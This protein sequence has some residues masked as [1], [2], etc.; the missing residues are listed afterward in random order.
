MSSSDNDFT[1]AETNGFLAKMKQNKVMSII[2][3]LVILAIIGA[4]FYFL[5]WVKTPQ[6]SLKL[7]RD[8]VE[9]HDVATFEKH[10]DLTTITGQAL[11]ALMAQEMSKEDMNNPLVAGIIQTMKPVMV[12]SLKNGFIEYVRSGNLELK[13]PFKDRNKQE[14]TAQKE[15]SKIDN[16]NKMEFKDIT[17]VETEGN[18]AKVSL[19]FHDNKLEK[20]FTVIIGMGKLED[21]TWRVD[22]LE[23]IAD[24][25]KE[26]NEATKAKL[27]QINQQ[28]ADEIAQNIV[29]N[30]DNT[31][32][33]KLNTQTV[34]GLL[35]GKLQISLSLQNKT[36]Q[37][38]IVNKFKLQAK[39]SEGNIAYEKEISGNNMTIQP[40]QVYPTKGQFDLNPFIAADK[41]FMEQFNNYKTDIMITSITIGDKT[42][43]YQNKL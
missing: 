29:I 15:E 6:Y 11:D 5:Y 38:I 14:A 13:D 43:E 41:K 21:G 27:A 8:S 37:P 4:A 42:I 31:Y 3:G 34:F 17:N 40:N 12:E 1:N 22:N 18:R 9:K 36:D 24:F 10:V 39:D 33:I 26:Y 32:S 7:I 23:N 16:M 30:Q 28:I 25:A 2:I 19:L 35:D 20:D